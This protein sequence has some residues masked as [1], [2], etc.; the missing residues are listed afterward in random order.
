L[1][2]VGLLLLSSCFYGR[3]SY[4]SR[5]A[6]RFTRRLFCSESSGHAAEITLLLCWPILNDTAQ[7]TQS[8]ET[9]DAVILCL[10]PSL[11][12]K[13]HVSLLQVRLFNLDVE[14]ARAKSTI[15]I[16]GRKKISTEEVTQGTVSSS[17]QRI[18]EVLLNLPSAELRREILP[19]A[20]VSSAT[21]ESSAQYEAPSESEADDTEQLSTTPLQLLQ[22]CKS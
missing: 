19:E 1:H 11:H 14:Q 3:S 20:F 4:R 10:R 17:A 2:L 18:L 13:L 5:S 22:V 12:L 7:V 9:C 8:T 6:V 21:E 16:I 15:Q